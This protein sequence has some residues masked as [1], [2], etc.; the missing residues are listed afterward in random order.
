MT[1]KKWLQACWIGFFVL[2]LFFSVGSTWLISQ[3]WGQVWFFFTS[4]SIFVVISIYTLN[5]GIEMVPQNYHWPVE[6]VGQYYTTWKPG[7]HIGFPYLGFMIIAPAVY[8]GE[9]FIELY[10][11]DGQPDQQGKGSVDFRDV[12]A[13]VEAVLYYQIVDSM[14]FTYDIQ[15]AL[16]ALV[17]RIDGMMRSYLGHYTL[18]EANVLKAQFDIIAIMSGEKLDATTNQVTRY[19]RIED[20][21]AWQ[22]ILNDWG[23]KVIRVSISDIVLSPAIQEIRHKRQIA[24]VQVEVAIEEKKVIITQ[25]EAKKQALVLEGEGRKSQIKTLIGRD[26]LTGP[27]AAWLVGE[28][29]KWPNLGDKSLVLENGGSSVMSL[30]AQFAAGVRQAPQSTAPA[31]PTA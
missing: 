20:V 15:N 10:M 5:K 3:Y 29:I 28:T 18:D 11:D 21:P 26:C 24:Q 9:A 17:E 27:Q 14:K 25:A 31:T 4:F 7:L 23:I 12:S 22:Q 6:V 2:L 8:M 1:P 30:G 19:S 13:P 16:V